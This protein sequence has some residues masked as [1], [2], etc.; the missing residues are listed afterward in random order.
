M[1]KSACFAF[2]T[3]MCAGLANAL[4]FAALGTTPFA[5]NGVAQATQYPDV[6]PLLLGAAWYPE[7]WDEATWEKDLTLMEAGHVHLARIAEFA[8]STMEPSEGNFQFEWLDHAIAMAA[9]HHIVIV[10]GTPTAAP[11]VWLTTK[12]PETL[13]V[14]N[15]G[16]RDEH[17]NRQQFSFA[18]AKYRFF[19][20]RISEKMAERYGHNPNVVGW[21]LDNELANDSFDPEAKAQFHAWLE[22]KYGTIDKL[23]ALWT[24]AYWSQTYD[25]F[26]EIPVHNKDENPALLLDWKHFVSE[27]WKSYCENEISAIRPYADKRQFITTNTMGWFDGFD[28]YTVHSVLDMASWDDYVPETKFDP[29]SNGAEHDLT[30]SYKQKNFWVMETEPAFVNWRKNN[31]AINKGQMREMA[32]QA[33]GH[34][35][36]AVEYWQWRAALNG[37]EQYHGTLAGVDG[38]PVPA[39]DEAKQIG[40]EFEKAGA[41]LAGTTPVASVAVMESFDSRWA[42]DFQR[43]NDAFDPIAELVAFYGPLRAASQG[44]DIVPPS[45][46]LTKYKLVVA[47]ALN[48]LNAADANRLI[49]YVKQ[50]GHLVLGPRSAMKNEYDATWTQ[51]QPGPLVDLLGGR[52]EE[53]YALAADAPVSGVIGSGEAEVWAEMLEPKASDTK[54]LLTYGASNGWLDGKPAMITRSVGK[55]VITY[56]GF[57]PDEKLLGDMATAWVQEADVAPLVTGVPEGVEV[58]ERT[59]AGKTVVILINHTTSPQAVTVPA[60]MKALVGAAG[61]TVTLEKYG[62]AVFGK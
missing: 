50:G 24:T 16:R 47:P 13:R 3:P 6:P 48:V 2:R 43:F 57:W 49:A 45:G 4:V 60:G 37:Q 42:I 51:R 20:H 33:I 44:I 11:P 9:K 41:A 54:T 21:Q 56:V 38:T 19:A 25:N 34:G 29:A 58:C 15:D 40:E 31:N 32:W 35:A 23:N 22:K 10:L 52:V 14:D 8:W 53:K 26:D 5:P 46:D 17:G 18:S 55:G 59:G 12:Y 62:V 1:K 39:F 61:S 36:D 28:A 7:Q 27:T 30:R